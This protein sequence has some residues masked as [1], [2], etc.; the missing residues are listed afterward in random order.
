MEN[1]KATSCSS[2]V[3]FLSVLGG[4]ACFMN[5]SLRGGGVCVKY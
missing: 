4:F 1:Q 5:Q 3:N 2:G